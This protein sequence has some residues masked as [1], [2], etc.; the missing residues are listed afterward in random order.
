QGGREPARRVARESIW[1]AAWASRRKSSSSRL[2]QPQILRAGEADGVMRGGEDEA[3]TGEVVAHQGGQ[4]GARG[5][6]E[7]GGGFVQQPERPVDR[8]QPGERQPPPLP[9]REVS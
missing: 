8:D 6:V 4:Q 9:R 1:Q 3:A 5:A 2:S 7:R